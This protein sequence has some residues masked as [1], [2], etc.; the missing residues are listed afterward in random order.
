MRLQR[1]IHGGRQGAIPP[2]LMTFIV[3]K[4]QSPVLSIFPIALKHFLSNKAHCNFCCVCTVQYTQIST[5]CCK[6]LRYCRCPLQSPK[7]CFPKA[8]S[9]LSQKS[10]TVAEF[11]DCRRCFAVFCD[12]LTFLRQCGQGISGFDSDRC[13]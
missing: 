6:F 13:P 8:L 2:K 4:K 12:S 9:T 5:N 10:A 11:G 3:T 1:R 7:E